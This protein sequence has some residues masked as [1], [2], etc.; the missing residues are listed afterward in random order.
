MKTKLININLGQ[1]KLN[2]VRKQTSRTIGLALVIAV[3][4]LAQTRPGSGG[5]T[6]NNGHTAPV[7]AIGP[8]PG[9]IR[10]LPPVDKSD[11]D[12]DGDLTIPPRKLYPPVAPAQAGA[13]VRNALDELDLPGQPLLRLPWGESIFNLGVPIHN[14]DASTR[15]KAAAS[16]QAVLPRS[17]ALTTYWPQGASGSRNDPQ[18]AAGT[19]AIGVL[20]WDNLAFYDKSGQ[21]LPATPSFPNPTNTETLFAPIVQIL[22]ANI[23]LDPSVAG[24]P[25]FHF[26]NGQRGDARLEFD[27]FRK[28]WVILATAKNNPK[29]TATYPQSL[30]ISQRRTKFMLAV[31]LDE[32]PSH[33]FN[34]YTY[35]ADP[36][37]GAC[38]NLVDPCPGT[39]YTPG[40]GSDYPS[41]GM[42][43]RHYIMTI[44]SG[45]TPLNGGPQSGSEKWAY[46]VVA[47]ADDIAGGLGNPRAQEFWKWYFGNNEY[48]DY[49]AQPLM[50]YQA[51]APID[52]GLVV[53]TSSLTGHMFVTGITPTDPPTLT[54]VS[55]PMPNLTAVPLSSEPGMS[56]P[57]NYGNVGNGPIKA[58]QLGGTLAVAWNDCRNWQSIVAPCSPS[59]HVVTATVGS[60]PNVT[61]KLDRV[62][63]QRNVLDDPA[64]SIV[65]YGMPGVAVNKNNDLAIVYARTSAALNPEVRYSTWLHGEPDIRPSQLMRVGDGFFACASQS[66]PWVS[67]D[68]SG[69]ALD[70]YGRTGIWLAH[71]YLTAAGAYGLSVGKVFGT[72]RPGPAISG[73]SFP[74]DIRLTTGAQI[75]VQYHVTNYGDGV[76]NPVSV[77]ITLQPTVGGQVI[78]LAKTLAGSMNPGQDI[79]QTVSVKLP[80]LKGQ[81]LMKVAAT[82]VGNADIYTKGAN[83]VEQYI[84]IF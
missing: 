67:P 13:S 44:N 19:W 77:E 41:L 47:N 12:E 22:D 40:N 48:A 33:G 23:K 35:N 49:D 2:R 38:G 73:L 27:P 51:L 50:S 70:P 7:F 46:M 4:G 64:G 60:F 17:P 6:R 15:P 83:F 36:D 1:T 57:I 34:V 82:V 9:G 79:L 25:D 66:C 61:A 56:L 62:F 63:G 53:S 72:Q 54:S 42:S 65:D 80:G 58:T 8:I 71:S 29:T 10:P 32:D 28:R 52:Y 39:N 84:T 68:T 20:T 18:V 16:P 3:V 69:I 24:N 78:S 43:S 37:D 14:E 55:I 5:V 76:A 31:S 74:G 11:D 59:V 45:H 75:N 81:Y 30:L 21:L 26:A